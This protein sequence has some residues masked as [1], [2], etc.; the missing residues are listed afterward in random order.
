VQPVTTLK[1]QVTKVR[2]KLNET[3]AE[4]TWNASVMLPGWR[5]L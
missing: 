3:I 5:C 2:G 4:Q 1:M